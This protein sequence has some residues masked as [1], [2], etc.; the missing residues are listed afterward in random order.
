MITPSTKK[1][2]D[3]WKAKITVT[4]GDYKQSYYSSDFFCTKETAKKHAEWWAYESRIMGQV[5]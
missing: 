1:H 5:V 3:Y 4:D 2:G